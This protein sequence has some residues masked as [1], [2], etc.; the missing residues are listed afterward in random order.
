MVWC[1]LLNTVQFE[2]RSDSEFD[3]SFKVKSLAV[4][5]REQQKKASGKVQSTDSGP[6]GSTERRGKSGEEL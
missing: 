6:E 4:K 5:E 3:H 2:N 1:P